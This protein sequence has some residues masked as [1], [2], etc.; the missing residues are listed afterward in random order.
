[1]VRNGFAFRLLAAVAFFLGRSDERPEGTLLIPFFCLP[2]ETVSLSWV[3]QEFLSICQ[4]PI[5][6]SVFDCIFFLGIYIGQADL[7]HTQFIPSDPS[8]K[9]LL[10]AFIGV[11]QP[12]PVFLYQWYGKWPIFMSYIENH[13][14]CTRLFQLVFLF[15]EIDKSFALRFVCKR[16]ARGNKILAPGPE[17]SRQ[18]PYILGL[19][20]AHHVLDSLIRGS[21]SLLIL[22][23]R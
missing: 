23:H 4:N 2:V 10:P 16:I 8:G 21:K 7:N 22:Q 1:V 14:G 3:T 12:C 20:C 18:S 17:N 11:E 6:I 13:L 15:V 5:T 19:Q 9:N